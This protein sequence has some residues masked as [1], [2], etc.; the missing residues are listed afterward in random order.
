MTRIFFY[1][2]LFSFVGEVARAEN[3][4]E[5]LESEWD[6]VHDVKFT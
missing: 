5:G 1:S 3:I 2:V 6:W 4:Y